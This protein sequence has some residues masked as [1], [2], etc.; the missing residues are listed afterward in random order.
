MKNKKTILWTIV[1]ALLA[2]CATCLNFEN[3]GSIK[4][5]YKYFISYYDGGEPGTNY[6]IYVYHNYQILVEERN[7]CTTLDCIESG[8]LYSIDTYNVKVSNKN[9]AKVKKFV[10]D[11]FKD[12]KDNKIELLWYS[13]SEREENALRA[14]VYN[15]E[16]FWDYY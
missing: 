13:L 15:D 11:L 7:N 1:A 10:N 2:L 16:F 9:K 5:N 8:K 4:D 3:T 12:E 6:D 14:I